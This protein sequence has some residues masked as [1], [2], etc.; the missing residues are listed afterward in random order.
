MNS[1]YE[2]LKKYIETKYDYY[3]ALG[4]FGL[5]DRESLESE[6]S[7]KIFSDLIEFIDNME[8]HD[9]ISS[10]KIKLIK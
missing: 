5:G 6:V 3:A 2:R 7:W 9:D 1:N 8:I 4:Q 10:Q